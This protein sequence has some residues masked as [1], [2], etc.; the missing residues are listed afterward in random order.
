M[1]RQYLSNHIYLFLLFQP[2]TS[3][4]P[5]TSS[6]IPSMTH[7]VFKDAPPS[8]PSQAQQLAVEAASHED[9][10]GSLMRLFKNAGFMKLTVAY[11]EW[12][13]LNLNILDM[14]NT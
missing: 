7:E 13:N 11:G 9:Y 10:F 6:V 2:P 8:P 5:I 4:S 1:F 3:I 12:L 14:A